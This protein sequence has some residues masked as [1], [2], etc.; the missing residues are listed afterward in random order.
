MGQGRGPGFGAGAGAA[1]SVAVAERWCCGRVEVRG[2]GERVWASGGAGCAGC[3]GCAGHKWAAGGRGDARSC[4][5]AAPNRESEA[6]ELANSKHQ[7]A[8]SAARWPGHQRRGYYCATRG[9]P[10]PPP[11]LVPRPVPRS[12]FAGVGDGGTAVA[13][14]RWCAG[15]AHGTASGEGGSVV[16][17]SPPHPPRAPCV[18]CTHRRGGSARPKRLGLPVQ[19]PVS[20]SWR[21]PPPTPIRSAPAAR[22]SPAKP[23]AA[24][25]VPPP[26]PRRPAVPVA[27]GGRDSA[28]RG[29][30]AGQC[31]PRPSPRASAARPAEA[32]CRPPPPPPRDPAPR[33]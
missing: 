25:S 28:P 19:C 8:D 21:S 18:C 10:V 23:P 13:R 15:E 27:P 16:D 30:A 12:R 5:F 11:H 2:A 33:E 17:V 4:D 29:H 3:A 24:P 14:G 6:S 9:V 22:R 31:A 32:P 1:T 7:R 26:L 20:I